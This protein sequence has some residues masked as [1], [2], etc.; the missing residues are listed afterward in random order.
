MA[1]KKQ[2]ESDGM[3][4]FPHQVW[5]MLV[6]FDTAFSV[7]SAGVVVTLACPLTVDIDGVEQ[8]PRVKRQLEPVFHPRLL[9]N[10]H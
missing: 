1:R 5:S 6:E 10:M 2:S 9:K 8:L 4:S 3:N 7:A